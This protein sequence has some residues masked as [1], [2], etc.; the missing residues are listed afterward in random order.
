MEQ[1]L[2]YIIDYSVDIFF[3]AVFIVSILAGLK[4]GLA[5]MLITVLCAAAAV[6]ISKIFSPEL[7]NR[8]YYDF[9]EQRIAEAVSSRLQEISFSGSTVSSDDLPSL[10]AYA[11]QFFNADVSQITVSG[12]DT[13]QIA[14]SVVNKL[15][16]IVIIPMLGFIM[17]TVLTI[18]IFVVLRPLLGPLE[19]IFDLPILKQVNKTA[20]MIIGAV[21][22]IFI[23]FIM[24]CIA[25]IAAMIMPDSVVAQAVQSSKITGLVSG[26]FGTGTVL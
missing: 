15:A 18:L 20:G 1:Y 13:M 6:V 16:E 17:F 19:H 26:I 9:L 5:G 23:V 3:V 12:T 21:K 2:P 7:S 4:K 24:A 10:L 8:L 22:G 11:V 14:Q 25:V